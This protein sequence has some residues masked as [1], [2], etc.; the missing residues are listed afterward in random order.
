MEWVYIVGIGLNGYGYMQFTKL[1][2]P[3]DKTTT[4]DGI[5]AVSAIGGLVSVFLGFLSFEWW[6]PIT[7]LFGAPVIV[8]LI[9]AFTPMAK[10]PLFAKGIGLFLSLV[11][12]IA[13]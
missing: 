5:N 8:G 3:I 13:A 6:I 11:G 2:D 9:A 10:A 12:L 7:G 4:F 1:L